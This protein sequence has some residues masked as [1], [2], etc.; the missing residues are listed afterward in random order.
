MPASYLELDPD[1]RIIL[2]VRRHWISI[3]PIIVSTI[4]VLMFVAF[5]L[6]WLGSNPAAVPPPLTL[7]LA[8]SVLAGLGILA[9]VIGL[10]AYLVYRQNRIILT[11]KHYLQINQHGLFHRTV[12]KLTLDEIQDV[13]GTKSG[14]FA[15]VLNYGE[16]LIETAGAEPNFLFRPAGNPLELGESI[17]DAHHKF[18]HD[19]PTP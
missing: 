8:W 4:L 17:N 1:E 10:V 15:T 7:P 5:A 3:F 18:G 6:G 16:I 11:N 2:T 13:R 19:T 9:A 12:S 14:F